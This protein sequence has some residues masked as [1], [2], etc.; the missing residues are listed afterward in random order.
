MSKHY[1]ID[2]L[3]EIAGGE[4]DFMVVVAQTFLEEIPPDLSA[5]EE[6]VG[7]D[8]KELA[9]QFAHKMK[10][11]LE[12]F[13]IDLQKEITTVESWTRT[14]K[15]K[16]VIAE[17]IETISTTLHHVFAELKSDFNL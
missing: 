14:S 10:P 16:A 2:S 17:H 15:S 4:A 7:N 9:Y 11:N 8:N 3:R 1:S 6:A 13:G 5:M 12:M